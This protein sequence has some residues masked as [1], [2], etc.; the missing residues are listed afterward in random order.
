MYLCLTK[1]HIS[2]LLEHI[3]VRHKYNHS[4]LEVV[5]ESEAQEG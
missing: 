4:Q 1:T 5:I 2:V 3:F